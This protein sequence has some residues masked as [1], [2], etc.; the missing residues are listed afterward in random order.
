MHRAVL[1]VM[2]GVGLAIGH[3]ASAGTT[4]YFYD[5]QGRVTGRTNSAGWTGLYQTDPA[6]NRTFVQSSPIPPPTTVNTLSNTQSI[7]RATVMR[8]SD[9]RY[10]LVLQ[11]DG[12]LV[13]YGPAGVVWSANTAGTTAAFLTMEPDGNLLLCDGAWKVVWMSGTSGNPNA[14][15]TLQTDG[16]LVIYTPTGA[17]IWDTGP[18]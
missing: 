2:L 8:S 11:A 5:A 12:N 17:T 13:E 9:W 3:S 6:D 1:G 18:A 15:L 4:N 10:S 16:N 7:N 14:A